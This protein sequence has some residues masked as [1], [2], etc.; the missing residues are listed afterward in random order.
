MCHKPFQKMTNLEKYFPHR[1]HIPNKYRASVEKKAASKSRG[2]WSKHIKK[3]FTEKDKQ[4]THNLLKNAKLIVRS[5]ECKTTLRYHFPSKILAE[6]VWQ[7]V[8]LAAMG[9]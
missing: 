5:I 6:K 1:I 8:L 3:E 4:I 7:L 2:I 9:I